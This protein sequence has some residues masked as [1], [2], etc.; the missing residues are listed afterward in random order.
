MEGIDY[1][2]NWDGD[3]NFEDTRVSG[4]QSHPP[5]V[6]ARGHTPSDLETR[7]ISTSVIGQTGK[8]YFFTEQRGTS[9]WATDMNKAFQGASN[10][11][12]KA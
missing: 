9:V 8:K 2:I 11:T 1:D 10:L 3:Q 5:F 6:I 7:L 12:M 4:G